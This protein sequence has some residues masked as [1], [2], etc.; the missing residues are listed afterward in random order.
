MVLGQAVG[1]SGQ[2]QR[3]IVNVYASQKGVKGLDER[4]I[5]AAV[6]GRGGAMNEH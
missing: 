3:R 1:H 2:D 5:G 4:A 6:G